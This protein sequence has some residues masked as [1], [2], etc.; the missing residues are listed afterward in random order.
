MLLR[1]KELVLELPGIC[2]RL[3]SSG[4]AYGKGIPRYVLPSSGPC[5]EVYAPFKNWV[6]KFREKISE[7]TDFPIGKN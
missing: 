6:M 3:S 4:K 5:S 1:G 2:E 7:F